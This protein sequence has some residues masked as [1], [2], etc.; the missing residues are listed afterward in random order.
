MNAE[1]IA[2]VI[3]REGFPIEPDHVRIE[4]P[5]KELGL[6]SIKVQL[7][8]DIAGEVK[9]WVVPTHSEDGPA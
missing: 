8:P 5:L 4:G 2:E 6:Y 9:L 7:A 1:Q 3:K